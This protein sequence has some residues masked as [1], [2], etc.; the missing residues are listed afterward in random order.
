M[1]KPFDP[2]VFD[3]RVFDGKVDDIRG[4]VGGS[5][6]EASVGAI[7]RARTRLGSSVTLRARVGASHG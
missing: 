2:K 5:S 7:V 3:T 4:S 6:S 1:S